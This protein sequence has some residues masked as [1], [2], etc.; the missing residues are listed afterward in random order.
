MG[1]YMP[2]DAA[3]PDYAVMNELCNRQQAQMNSLLYH[4]EQNAETQR[5]LL[6][7]FSAS[8]NHF[9]STIGNWLDNSAV[10]QS[11]YLLSQLNHYQELESENLT[12]KR[13][14]KESDSRLTKALEER[15]EYKRI[16]DGNDWTG[17][18]KVS[19][20]DVQ[21]KWKQL[22][23]N[24]RSLAKA[25]A[26]CPVNPPTTELAKERFSTI[27]SHWMDLLGD[28]DYREWTIHAYLWVVVQNLIF[29]GSGK[30]WGG[31]HALGFKKLRE[32]LL[33]KLKH[34]Y[35]RTNLTM[36]PQNMPSKFI[37]LNCQD[38]ASVKLQG[39]LSRVPLSLDIS[40]D[41]TRSV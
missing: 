11:E 23:Y 8:I 3:N 20:D 16:S 7:R 36:T 38:R 34:L 37:V 6:E 35:S 26:K 21:G 22:D 39:G 41:V 17:S 29:T 12:L 4:S 9:G 1:D 40:L 5:S 28:Q 15:D 32:V 18:V 10:K 14:L 27:A 19:D 25:L 31:D 13:Q 33:S 2:H 24:I 30:I